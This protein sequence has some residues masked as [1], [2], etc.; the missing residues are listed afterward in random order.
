METQITC[1]NC[2]KTM[3][4]NPLIDTAI[5]GEGSGKESIMHDCGE[6]ITYWQITAQLRDQ[7]KPMARFQNW[8][9]SRSK[10]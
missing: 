10:S 4:N 6:K 5:K 2:R 9:H 7:K 1:P 8:I 3:S